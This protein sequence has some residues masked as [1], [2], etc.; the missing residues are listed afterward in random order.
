MGGSAFSLSQVFVEQINHKTGQSLSFSKGGQLCL[1]MK[2]IRDL[3]GKTL[4]KM[5]GVDV[6]G[7]AV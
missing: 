7:V 1:F 5:K 3:N 4:H 2:G 6:K